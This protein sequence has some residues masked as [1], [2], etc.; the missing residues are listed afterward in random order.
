MR[1]V[2]SHTYIL[3]FSLTITIAFQLKLKHVNMSL[4][5][6]CRESTWQNHLLMTEMTLLWPS[7]PSLASLQHLA[8]LIHFLLMG[9]AYY[10]SYENIMVSKTHKL[11]LFSSKKA[12]P[13]KCIIAQQL[14]TGSELLNSPNFRYPGPP[15]CHGQTRLMWHCSVL[16]FVLVYIVIAILK[17]SPCITSIMSCDMP[18]LSQGFIILTVINY[19][20][21][22]SST[23][24]T[25]L[26]MRWISLH[27][28]PTTES[29]AIHFLQENC[30]HH[31]CATFGASLSWTN[32]LT[33]SSHFLQPPVMV[34][35]STPPLV[36]HHTASNHR[37]HSRLPMQPMSTLALPPINNLHNVAHAVSSSSSC[38]FFFFLPPCLQR[39]NSCNLPIH[40]DVPDASTHTTAAHYHWTHLPGLPSLLS[41]K[42][43]RL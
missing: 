7:P 20:M 31:C 26:Q 21:C 30:L 11:P 12:S 38:F 6:R 2:L 10:T 34:V 39:T 14:S 19:R 41:Q 9:N 36:M 15:F 4:E 16:I 28:F 8:L 3:H 18:K 25:L 40:A 33:V 42:N 27:H 23:V 17:C 32:Q 43:D 5:V 1:Y 29:T 35:S 13:F 24:L 22:D 37:H